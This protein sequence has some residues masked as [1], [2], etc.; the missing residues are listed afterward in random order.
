MTPENL[1]YYLRG[2]AETANEPPTREQ[3]GVLRHTILA[4]TTEPPSDFIG[5]VMP[6]EIAAL[7]NRGCKGCSPKGFAPTPPILDESKLPPI[8]G[9]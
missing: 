7:M 8:E 6:P 3:W 4:A 1:A 2:F 9:G 5:G